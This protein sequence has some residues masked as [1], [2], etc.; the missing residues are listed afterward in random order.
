MAASHALIASGP[1]RTVLR[2]RGPSCG[3]PQRTTDQLSSSRR[4]GPRQRTTLVKRQGVGH[5]DRRNYVDSDLDRLGGTTRDVLAGDAYGIAPLWVPA[6]R[7]LRSPTPKRGALDPR[8]RSP[9]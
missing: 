4:A 8:R 5:D 1:R 6:K 9:P 3:P 2:A 7:S